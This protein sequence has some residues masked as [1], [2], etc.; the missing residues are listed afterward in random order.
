V[1][2][3]AFDPA[4]L[5]QKPA[6]PTRA[7]HTLLV[8]GD[9]LSTPLDTEM[10][11]RLAGRSGVRTIRDPHLGTGISK[12]L[13]VDW[14][15]LSADQVKRDRPDAV[16]VFIGANEGFPLPGQEGKNVE[17]CGPD[18]A[19]VYATRVRRMM[20]TYRRR[21]AGR[22]YG[23][24]LPAPRDSDRR[25]IA[26]TVNASIYAAAAPYRAQVRVLDM[27]AIF[28]PGFKYRDAMDVDGRKQIVRESD[29]IHLNDV[30]VRPAADAVLQALARDF[31]F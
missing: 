21:G 26:R 18:W 4:A 2:R 31:R 7:L 17:C 30:G 5:G 10:A 19:A 27:S 24:T 11:K 20:E 22:V 12:S 8:T 23:L 29:G 13:L 25:D 28:T 9:S 6:A 14:G 15:Q 1:T 16:V 3:D